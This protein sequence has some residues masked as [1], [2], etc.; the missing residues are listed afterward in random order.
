PEGISKQTWNS[1]EPS[2]RFLLRG[3]EFESRGEHRLGAFQELARSY[4][5]RDYDELLGNV[6]ANEARVK[7]AKEFGDRQFEGD[8]GVTLLRQ[9]LYAIHAAMQSESA[10]DGRAYLRSE[11]R[12]YWQKRQTIVSILRFIAKFQHSIPDRKDECRM[13]EI[14]AGLLDNDTA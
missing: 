4:G 13:A 11:R 3:L 8:F 10:E 1:L 14:L 7:T 2:A 12:D 9:V 6:K 5:I